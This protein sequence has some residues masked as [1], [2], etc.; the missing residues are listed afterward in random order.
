[1]VLSVILSFKLWTAGRYFP[2][3]PLFDF[4]PALKNPFDLALL[5]S[6][7]AIVVFIFIYDYKKRLHIAL[8]SLMGLLAIFDQ[9][10]LQPWFYQSFLLLLPLLH[11]GTKEFDG[12]ASV[13]A[14]NSLKLVLFGI[15][16][17]NGINKLNPHYFSEAVPWLCKPFEGTLFLPFKILFVALPIL[18][19]ASSILFWFRKTRTLALIS[20]VL[21]QLLY[22]VSTGPLGHNTSKAMWPWHLVVI[23]FALFC[24]PEESNDFRTSFHELKQS[25]SGKIIVVAITILPFLGLFNF[26]DAYLSFNLYSGGSS[27]AKIYLGE[28]VQKFLP[29]EAEKY[30]NDESNPNVVDIRKWSINELGVPPYPEKRVYKKVKAYFEKYSDDPSEIVLSYIPKQTLFRS[31]EPEVE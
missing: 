21:I 19:I 28:D 2:L 24:F 11:L 9:N 7:T 14:F 26:W 8:L 16:L 18:E 30:F 5:L 17:W 6:G 13:K 4:I 15:I 31:P 29:K 20:L 1:M 23:L 12:Q 25:I 10:R 27:Q 3:V 22:L